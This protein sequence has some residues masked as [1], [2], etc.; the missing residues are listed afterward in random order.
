MQRRGGK[1]WRIKEKNE[2]KKA[3]KIKLR[4]AALNF[5][6]MIGKGKEMADLMERRGLDILC[7]SETH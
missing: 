7:V 4:A 5:G 3:K 2:R 6:T 1:Q